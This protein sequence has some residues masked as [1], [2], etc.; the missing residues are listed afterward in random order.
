MPKTLAE[1][2]HWVQSGKKYNYISLL[3]KRDTDGYHHHPLI[4]HEAW[5]QR[6]GPAGFSSS[7]KRTIVPL[8]VF[9]ICTLAYDFSWCPF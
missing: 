7:W 6:E 3:I 4:Y 8:L 5:F 1:Q 2:P 9:H